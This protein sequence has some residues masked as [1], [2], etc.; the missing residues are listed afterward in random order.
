MSIVNGRNAV[1]SRKNTS[2]NILIVDDEPDIIELLELT[3]ARM[4]MD[5]VS[6]R[7]LGEAKDR[8]QS[9]RFQ[10]CLTD[11]R[12]PDGD[13]LDLVANPV[14][15]VAIITAPGTAENSCGA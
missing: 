7:S 13:G 4:G 3:L 9:K 10:L 1:A 2:P 11:M 12:L 8:L 14:R 15:L 5:V 6:A